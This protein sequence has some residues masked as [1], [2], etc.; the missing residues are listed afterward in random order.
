MER[1]KRVTVLWAVAWWGREAL[2]DNTNKLNGTRLM[3]KC[4]EI[5]GAPLLMSHVVVAVTN[6]Q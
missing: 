4:I 2:R 5:H 6:T 3:R 1:F